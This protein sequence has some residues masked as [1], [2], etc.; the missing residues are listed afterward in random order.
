MKNLFLWILFTYRLIQYPLDHYFQ[1]ADQ[2]SPAKYYMKG[3]IVGNKIQMNIVGFMVACGITIILFMFGK[4]IRKIAALVLA[5]MSIYS[6]VDEIRTKDVPVYAMILSGLVIIIAFAGAVK[7]KRCFLLGAWMIFSTTVG[8]IIIGN[9]IFKPWVFIETAGFLLIFVK[10][11]VFLV[12]K[13][14]TQT[15][16]EIN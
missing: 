10:G 14:S 2:Y 1:L 11:N 7:F 12:T 13:Q 3:N 15:A 8:F 16:T 5:L 6:F 9:H 4:N